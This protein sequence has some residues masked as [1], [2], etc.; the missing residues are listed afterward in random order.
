MDWLDNNQYN[1]TIKAECGALRAVD[2]YC[3]LSSPVPDDSWGRGGA[4][5]Y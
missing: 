4:I 2:F 5:C 3:A 1:A